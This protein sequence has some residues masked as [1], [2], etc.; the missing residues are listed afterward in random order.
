MGL[1]LLT[2]PVRRAG[3]VTVASRRAGGLLLLLVERPADD[4]RLPREVLKAGSAGHHALVSV[5]LTAHCGDR[6]HHL[7]P[8]GRPPGRKGPGSGAAM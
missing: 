3:M 2:R 1:L 4:Q 7:E 8:Q 6:G 5:A